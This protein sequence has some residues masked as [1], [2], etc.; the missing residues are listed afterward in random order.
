MNVA[1]LNFSHGAYP[2]HQVKI[3]RVKKVREKIKMPIALMLDT[4]GPEYR[5]KT[6]KDHKVTL[7]DGD[8]FTFT[9]DE[10]EG[11]ET[12][13]SVNYKNLVKELKVGDKVLVN[14]G[15]VILTVKK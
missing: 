11:D 6:F 15:L 4:K 14:N 1:R 5:I 13:V 8:E 3:D 9:T 2:D 7:K 10:V 12:K